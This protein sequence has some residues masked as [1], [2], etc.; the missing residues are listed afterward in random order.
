METLTDLRQHHFD[1]LKEIGNIGAGHSATALSRLLNKKISMNVPHARL[2][3]FNELV[4]LFGG[5][6]EEVA[7]VFLRIEGEFHGS[8]FFI[9]AVSQAEIF[10]STLLEKQGICLSDDQN[11][12]FYAS[13]FQE[14][15]NILTGSYLTAMGDLTGRVFM[16]SVPAVSIDMFG[17]VIIQG[18]VNAAVDEDHAILIDTKIMEETETGGKVIEGHFFLVPDP[19]SFSLL[20]QLAGVKDE[21]RKY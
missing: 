18:L 12:E 20:F 3:S 6:E 2:V 11:K 19:E 14:L 10:I 16:P 17:A 5:P 7:C 8:F 1:L 13:V 15:G 4:E 9:M 21:N